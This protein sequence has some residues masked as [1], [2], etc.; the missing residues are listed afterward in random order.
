MAHPHP[1]RRS[2]IGRLIETGRTEDALAALI[3]AAE[4]PEVES[5]SDLARSL[6]VVRQTVSRWSRVLGCRDQL[7][8]AIYKRGTEAAQGADNGD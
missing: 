2:R 8:D 4:R 7:D 6:G 3:A 1:R 5:R